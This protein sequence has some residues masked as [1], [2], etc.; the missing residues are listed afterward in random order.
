M[1]LTR[2]EWC[3][4]DP[5]YQSYHDNEWGEPTHDDRDLF[6]LLVLE[7]AEAGLS[8]ITI[9]KKRENYRR[10]FDNFDVRKVAQYDDAKVQELLQDAGIVRSEKKIRSAIQNAKAFIKIQEEFDTF[11]KYIW[12]FVNHKPIINHFAFSEVPAET[13]ESKAMSKDLI[14]RGF[15]FV[16]AKVC[17]AFMQATGMVNDHTRTCFKFPK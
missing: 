2:C 9:L 4:N 16:G 12:Q 13:D 1:T 7:G 3:S 17:Y 15:S 14:K 11:D 10:V 6:E 8:W 5:L